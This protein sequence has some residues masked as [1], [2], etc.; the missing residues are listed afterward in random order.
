MVKIYTIT[1]YNSF[2][3]SDIQHD[4]YI[5]M[6]D[7]DF[8]SLENFILSNPQLT[9]FMNISLKKGIGKS[10][11]V[12][13]YVG[14]LQVNDFLTIEILPKI[15]A[16][17]NDISHT[18]RTFFNMI[19]NL[20]DIP[21]KNFQKAFIQVDNVPMLDVFIMEFLTMLDTLVQK[22]LVSDYTSKV[23]NVNFL[24]G[25]LDYPKQIKYNTI[26]KERFYLKR[27]VFSIDCIE[28]RLIKSTLILLSRH[29][30]G[31]KHLI[32]NYLCYFDSVQ[33]SI[34]FQKDI[35]SYKITSKNIHYKDILRW[36]EVFLTGNGFLNFVGD[37][38]SYALLF[39][40][41]K[42]FES[43]VSS[44]VVKLCS[45]EYSIKLQ[46][47][48]NFLIDAPKNLF[49]IVPDIVLK[50]D[51]ETIILDTKWKMLNMDSKNYGISQQDMYQIYVYAK[52]YDSKKVFLI[53]PL[54]DDHFIGKDIKLITDDITIHIKFIKL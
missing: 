19:K 34:D 48:T 42:V 16:Y 24:K 32:Q 13:N 46:D 40:M 18:K 15:Y 37:S 36:C 35:L 31:Y 9:D 50:N 30:S 8:N 20:K 3:K 5:N 22:N 52:K 43:Y 47:R 14:I 28:N 44:L 23:E 6:N 21:F 29:T 17:Q 33:T 27:N 41:Q 49:A 10:I 7:D 38:Y 4:E 54:S 25:K 51:S 45:K 26:H 39:P 53:Y 11:S 2:I 1:E 12:R